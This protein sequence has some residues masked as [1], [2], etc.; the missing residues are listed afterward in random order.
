MK[1]EDTLLFVLSNSGGRDLIHDAAE[2]SLDHVV[3]NQ[4]VKDLPIIGSVAKLY[5]MAK[6]V[7]GYVFS[8][9][10]NRF[11]TELDKASDAEKK[12]FQRAMES[13]EI[14]KVRVAEVVMTFLDKMD[15]LEKAPLLAK[16][17]SGYIL[18]DYDFVT[19][20]RLS[21]AIDRCIATDLCYLKRLESPYALEGYIGDML[22]SAGLASIHGSPTVRAEIVKT[23]YL[24]SSLGE[25]FQQ[26]LIE[27][28]RYRT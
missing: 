19:F 15:D 8:K 22:A 11:L 7:H 16:A 12:E 23:H 21:T 1:F 3:D 14:D 9:K 26:V 4:V 2:F 28:R 18:G 13:G 27:G 5:A 25:L 20:Q 6:G 17:F 10:I 24:L